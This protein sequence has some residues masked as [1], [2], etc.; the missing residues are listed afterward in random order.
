L[1]PDPGAKPNWHRLDFTLRAASLA[2][3]VARILYFANN[4]EK[5]KKNRNRARQD[6]LR[7]TR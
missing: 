1:G 2:G 7:Q 3:V 4:D 6:A 5:P